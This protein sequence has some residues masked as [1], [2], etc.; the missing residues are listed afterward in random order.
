[1]SAAIFQSLHAGR[2]HNV[3]GLTAAVGSAGALALSAWVG[4]IVARASNKQDATRWD[5]LAKA[6]YGVK[7]GHDKMD[8]RS[9][10]TERRIFGTDCSRM[11]QRG[12]LVGAAH[13][14][15]PPASLSRVFSM[16]DT[17]PLYP[18]Q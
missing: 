11:R 15:P 9:F 2:S 13:H 10:G 12:Y 8:L 7:P 5:R 6:G 4:S 16:T 18:S 14:A 3:T 17:L 1:M